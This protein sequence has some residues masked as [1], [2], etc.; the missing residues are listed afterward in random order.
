MCVFRYRLEP[1]KV[2]EESRIMKILL[3]KLKLEE[4]SGFR[5][6]ALVS[7]ICMRVLAKLQN[8]FKE[9]SLELDF[10]RYILFFSKD[11]RTIL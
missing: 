10:L 7:R 5:V 8:N 4:T 9:T 6:L 3:S 1:V 11:Y 2:W